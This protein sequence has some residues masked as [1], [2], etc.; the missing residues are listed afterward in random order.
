[1][2]L[3]RRS[4]FACSAALLMVLSAPV[5][6]ASAATPLSNALQA[7]GAKADAD[8]IAL[9][10]TS[11][12]PTELRTQAVWD[13]AIAAGL[14]VVGVVEAGRASSERHRAAELTAAAG[15]VKDQPDV[16]AGLLADAA[17]NSKAAAEDGAAAAA[18]EA[19]ADRDRADAQTLWNAAAGLDNG[20]GPCV[21]SLGKAC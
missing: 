16:A 12:S 5:G 2:A 10:A 7:L 4:V 14:D 6:V 19:L 3:R 17:A 21:T 1:M 11:K 9:L 20:K 13:V 15:A 18:H 8:S